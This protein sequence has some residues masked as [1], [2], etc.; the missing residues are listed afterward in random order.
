MSPTDD[1]FEGYRQG[2]SDVIR[3]VV[4]V[5]VSVTLILVLGFT[6]W[7]GWELLGS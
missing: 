1:F 3:G 2:R 5:A 7:R 6:L 4:R